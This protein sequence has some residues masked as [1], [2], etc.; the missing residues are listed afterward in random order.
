[1]ITLQILLAEI[2]QYFSYYYN[3]TFDL[4]N[5]YIG[6]NVDETREEKNKKFFKYIFRPNNIYSIIGKSF[7][8]ISK[9]C[10]NFDLKL[11]IDIDKVEEFK[12]ITQSSTIYNKKSYDTIFCTV[13]ENN[14]VIELVVG[15][16]IMLLNNNKF[17]VLSPFKAHEL[18]V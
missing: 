2:M 12:K 17:T 16:Y 18:K 11:K 14:N 3:K 10:E 15:Y 5:Y 8:E 13:D 9:L 4:K 7:D 1:M 6:N